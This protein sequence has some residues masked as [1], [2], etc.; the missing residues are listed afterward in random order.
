MPDSIRLVGA[1]RSIGLDS[2][3]L[4]GILNVTPDS[5]SDGGQFFVKEQALRHARSMID[6]GADW[7][8]IGGESSGPGSIKTDPDEEL[9][10]VIPVIKGI[11]GESDIWLSIDTWKSKVAKEAVAAGADCI[12]DITALRG[13]A[14]MA[15]TVSELGCALVLMH[16][17]DDSSRT[18]VRQVE[19]DNVMHTLRN[20]F[21]ER[22]DFA[23]STGISR[24]SILLDPGMGYFISSRPEYSFEIVRRIP[25]L[26]ELGFPLLFGP[27]R[28]SFLAEVSQGSPLGPGERDFPCAAVSSIAVWQG[29]RVLR[30]HEVVQG[31]QILDTLMRIGI[32]QPAHE[33]G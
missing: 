11:R 7:I 19:Y 5:F 17:K 25:E 22:L 12:N 26:G 14:V 20:F 30:M 8:D 16:S 24:E 3:K 23:E 15:H 10:R 1:N 29:V 31:R 18:T 27:S 2:P 4:M 9:S 6:D 32:P 13:D 21:R 33:R 28:K